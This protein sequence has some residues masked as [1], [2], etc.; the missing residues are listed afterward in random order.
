MSEK[1]REAVARAIGRYDMPGDT[2]YPD[3]L[4]FED[5]DA[6]IAVAAPIIEAA[7][8]ERLAREAMTMPEDFIYQEILAIGD[9]ET[10]YTNMGSTVADW[11]RAQLPEE[12]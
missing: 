6:A 7:I 10:E 1:L 5:A 11:L 2:R 9:A 3:A 8:I 12:N 4:D